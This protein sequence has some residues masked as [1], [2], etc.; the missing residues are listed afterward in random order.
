ML[1]NTCL[2]RALSLLLKRS[3][4]MSLSH[5]SPEIVFDGA[6]SIGIGQERVGVVG[7]ILRDPLFARKQ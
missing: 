2:M 1:S 6:F 7:L 5:A 4:R 3:K